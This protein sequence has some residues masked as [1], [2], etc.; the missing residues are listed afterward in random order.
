VSWRGLH[1]NAGFGDVI[2]KSVFKTFREWMGKHVTA[3]RNLFCLPDGINHEGIYLSTIGKLSKTL[4]RG[5]RGVHETHLTLRLCLLAASHSREAKTLFH[6]WETFTGL[7]FAL[8]TKNHTPR[9][10][11]R[12]ICILRSPLRLR[13]LRLCCAYFRLAPIMYQELGVTNQR[14]C[15]QPRRCYKRRYHVSAGFLH[16]N[17]TTSRLA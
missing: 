16:I 6:Q 9:A 11:E 15:I 12:S 3:P 5:A 7:A 4:F 14:R 17:S 13:I 1:A 2:A 8:K 10:H